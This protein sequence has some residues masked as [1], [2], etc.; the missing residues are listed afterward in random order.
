MALDDVLGRV[1]GAQA[2]IEARLERKRKHRYGAPAGKHIVLFVVRVG[3]V[4][5][6]CGV[7]GCSLWVQYPG[8]HHTLPAR[9]PSCA[10]HVAVYSP[11]L[12]RV[13]E[14][15]P[16]CAAAGFLVAALFPPSTAHTRLTPPPCLPPP[17]PHPTHAHTGRREHASA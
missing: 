9:Q 11:L 10:V 13:T 6:V 17:T 4:W 7:C 1:C 15:T 8:R 5:G 16:V 12:R 14:V 3:C 2:L